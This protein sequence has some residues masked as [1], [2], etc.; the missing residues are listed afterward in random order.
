MSLSFTLPKCA[1]VGLLKMLHKI[2]N[3]CR[4]PQVLG[5]FFSEEPEKQHYRIFK[6]FF[7]KKFLQLICKQ[8]QILNFYKVLK[9]VECISINVVLHAVLLLIVK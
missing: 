4:I 6:I 5:Y 9:C 2:C 3:I 1:P 7:K 8:P